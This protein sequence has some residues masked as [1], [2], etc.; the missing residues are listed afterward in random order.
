M[1]CLYIAELQTMGFEEPKMSCP[2]K[3]DKSDQAEISCAPKEDKSV[4]VYM[5]HKF[6]SKA[7][8]S[9]IKTLNQASSPLKPSIK[10]SSTSPFK[11]ETI[12]NSCTS[13]SGLTKVSRNVFIEEEQYDSDIYKPPEATCS[14][15]PSVDSLQVKSSSDCSELIAED[16]KLEAEKALTNTI[17]KIEKKTR[18]YLGVPSSCYFLIDILKDEINIPK[19]YVMLCLNKIRLDLKFR[20]LTDDYGISPPNLSKIFMKNIPLIAKF[21]RP[22]IVELD[23][24]IIKKNLPMAFRH[25]YNN[26]SCIID[27]LEIEVQKPSK[28][29]NQAMTWSDYKK[30]N[31]IKYLISCTPNGLV[32]YISPG[33]GGRASD[34]C[35]VESCDFI[36][37]LKSGM[38]VMADRGFKHVE[39]YLKKSNI[40]LVR[41]P[42]VETGVKMTKSEAKLTKQIASLRIHIERIIR[43]LREFYM[44]R[45]HSCINL[46]FLKILDE[47]MIIAC[48]LI[49][50]QGSLVK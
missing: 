33:F 2:L 22:F 7:I 37:T 25:N 18:F 42:S 29:V 31:T 23:K 28:A 36:K 30:A 26:V 21:L 39:Q 3:V 47:I 14:S 15:S 32:N 8:Q 49:N 17:K 50:L 27:C 11:V 45:P 16:K 19:H 48:A 5:T 12:Q 24:D 38:V 20:H 6:R 44:L 1:T 46:K 35:I 34:T 13:V 41:P 4:Q 10:S 40:S 9:K 43:R